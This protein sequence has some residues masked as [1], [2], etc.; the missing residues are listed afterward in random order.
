[1]VFVQQ[2]EKEVQNVTLELIIKLNL[3]SQ[4]VENC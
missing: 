3:K 2:Y 1:M 4:G